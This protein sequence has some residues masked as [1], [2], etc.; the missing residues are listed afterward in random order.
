VDQL[1]ILGVVYLLGKTMVIYSVVMW[2][3]GTLPRVRI[4]QMMGLA[5]KVL[6]PLVLA[7]ILW[8]MVVLK[9]PGG[10]WLQYPLIL[11]GNLAVIWY[12]ARVLSQYFKS[13]QL[14]TKRAFTPRSLIGTM[15]P[16]NTQ[17]A[18]D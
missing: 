14:R 15:A 5:W 4:D 2:L 16:V 17:Q 3:K 1:P 13:E 12:V 11:L 9:L 6:V 18:G 7:L 10:P 8:Q